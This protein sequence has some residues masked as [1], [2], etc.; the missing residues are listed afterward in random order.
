MATGL[1]LTKG[2]PSGLY[3]NP[4]SHLLR[5]RL[6]ALM[7]SDASSHTP[8]AST[9]LSSCWRPCTTS[10]LGSTSPERL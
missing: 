3:R 8:N 6:P 10:S 2:A 1:D 4:S 9:W 5:M 7:S